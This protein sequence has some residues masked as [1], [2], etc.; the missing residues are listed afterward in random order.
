MSK[1]A[2]K[3]IKRINEELKV[4]EKM[5]RTL[6]RIEE[7]FDDGYKIIIPGWNPSDAIMVY[8]I[9]KSFPQ[10]EVGYRIYAQVNIGADDSEDLIFR[11]WE[12][13]SRQLIDNEMVEMVY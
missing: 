1:N 2:K 8:E 7:V 9:P 13:P 11:D 6:I 10:L 4:K 5:W 3:E 12:L